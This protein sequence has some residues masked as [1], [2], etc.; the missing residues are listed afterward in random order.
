MQRTNLY[1][2]LMSNNTLY[3]E[4]KSLGFIEEPDWKSTND[5]HLDKVL[6]YNPVYDQDWIIDAE[7]SVAIINDKFYW[8]KDVFEDRHYSKLGI[9]ITSLDQLANLYAAINGKPLI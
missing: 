6:H 5:L 1:I 4:I 2:Y 8:L 3:S 7:I 9:E